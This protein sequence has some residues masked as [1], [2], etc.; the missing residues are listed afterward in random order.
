MGKLPSDR[1]RACIVGLGVL[2]GVIVC[3][4]LGAAYTTAGGEGP[5]TGAVEGAMCGLVLGALAG[6][7]FARRS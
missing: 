7:I 3:A 5:A 2:F 1:S 6:S 4:V